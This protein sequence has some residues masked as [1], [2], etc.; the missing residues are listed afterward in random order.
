MEKE[1]EK[2]GTPLGGFFAKMCKEQAIKEGA[3][4]VVLKKAED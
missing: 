3:D 1:T 2:A 4:L